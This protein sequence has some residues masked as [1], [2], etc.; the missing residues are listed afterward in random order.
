MAEVEVEVGG[1]ELAGA[2]EEE[3]NQLEL[4]L[5]KEEGDGKPAA[6]KPKVEGGD[7]GHDDDDD[8]DE[9]RGKVDSELDGAASDTD[10]EAIRAR[11]REERKR[12]K[13]FHND[14][15]DTLERTVQAQARQ[16]REA[17]ETLLRLQNSDASDKLGQLDDAIAE[18]QR[19]VD[20]FKAIHAD[21]VA[22]GDGVTAGEAM[23]RFSQARDRFN[24][25]T[26]TKRNIVE[27]Q[28]R[29]PTPPP[30]D[31]VVR[32]NAQEFGGRHKW[33]GGARSADPDSKVLTM[34]DAGI[35]QEG[36][37]PRTPEY[38]AELEARGRRY[39]P[40]RFNSAAPGDAENGYT[41]GAAAGSE[42]A[43]GNRRPRSPV[44]GAGQQRNGAP[45]EGEGGFKLSVERVKAM[46]ESGNWDDPKKRAA[47]V[48][49]YK[50]YDKDNAK[51]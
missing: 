35:T 8:E 7:A 23:E 5:Q 49:R 46:K 2:T 34:L 28:T 42:P 33:Y 32:R 50:A 19:H 47:M 40:H 14:K 21:A 48:A 31:P 13:Q 16:L 29:A 25:L 43:A 17:Q 3:G 11:R 37:D 9:R 18:A 1:Q 15:V 6:P 20:H 45:N 12:R 41:D 26:G 38:W 36:F 4:E 44:G 39:L 22:K 27:S 24:N 51:P 30:I 10:R